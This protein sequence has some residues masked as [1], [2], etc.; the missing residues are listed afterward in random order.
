MSVLRT[1]AGQSG[2]TGPPLILGPSSSH[3]PAHNAEFFLLPPALAAILVAAG[4][5]LMT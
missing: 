4:A 5:Q 3:A 1:G 2:R